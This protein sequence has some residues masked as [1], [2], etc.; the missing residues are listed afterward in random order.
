M[1]VFPWGIKGLI[2]SAAGTVK[3][4]WCTLPA[5]GKTPQQGRGKA[6]G[7]AEVMLPL[8]PSSTAPHAKAVEAPNQS[9]Y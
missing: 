7:I 1:E 5:L 3:Q 9:A 4:A 2:V 6:S 8:S